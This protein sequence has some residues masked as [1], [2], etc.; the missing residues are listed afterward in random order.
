MGHST[1][2]VPAS[3]FQALIL[4]G[5]GE[6]LNT[7]SSNPEE[8]P[9]ALIPIALKPMVTWVIE[10]CK[11]AGINGESQLCAYLKPSPRALG[12][13]ALGAVANCLLPRYHAGHTSLR[14]GSS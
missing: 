11:R 14:S 6:S 12:L 7:I 1:L 8:K 3:G 9:K 4:C 10:W 5:P 13:C 2:P